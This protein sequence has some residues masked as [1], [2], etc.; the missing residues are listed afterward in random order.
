MKFQDIASN[1]ERVIKDCLEQVN[2]DHEIEKI[3]NIYEGVSGALLAIITLKKNFSNT[4]LYNRLVAKFGDGVGNRERRGSEILSKYFSGDIKITPFIKIDH[5]H[6]HISRYIPGVT[7]HQIVTSGDKKGPDAV[8]RVMLSNRSVWLETLGKTNGSKTS[9]Y[10]SKLDDTLQIFLRS[11]IN[12]E[13]SDVFLE[14]LQDHSLILNG[15]RLPTIRELLSIMADL[16]RNTKYFA[17]QHGDEGFGN[18]VV[19]NNEIFIVDNEKVGTRPLGEGIAKS[20]CWFHVILSS[21]DYFKIS[22]AN[23]ELLIDSKPEILKYVDDIVTDSV[24]LIQESDLNRCLSK[25][26]SR[27]FYANYFIRELQWLVKR[28]REYMRPYIIEMALHNLSFMYSY[29]KKKE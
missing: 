26:E 8:R 19:L 24:R 25:A 17:L 12:L 2:P 28:R 23:K 5:P 27:A 21:P 10:I 1:I 20:V 13:S 3:E 22:E 11:P 29:Y 16:I 7:I 14:E 18:Y 9:N 6:L 4:F 15:T